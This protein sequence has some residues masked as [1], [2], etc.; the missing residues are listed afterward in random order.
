[1]LHKVRHLIWRAANE[2]L[3]TLHNLL[4]RN[5]VKSTHYPNCKSDGEDTI[6][7]LW[8]CKWLMVVWEADEEMMKFTKQKHILFADFWVVLLLKKDRVDV[9]LLVVIFWL[10]W[11]RRN[12][13]QMGESI[14]NYHQIRARVDLYLLFKSTKVCERR[15]VAEGISTVRWRPPN[16][17]YYKINFD[18]AV[19]SDVEAASLGVV[20]CDSYGR[21]IGSLAECVP[22]LTSVTTV[23]ALAC[24][25]LYCLPRS[26]AFL[27]Q[28]LKGMQ[29][30]SSRRCWAKR[31]II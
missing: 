11:N 21:V 18:G 16:P 25:G 19:F 13:E 23:E 20:I 29:S 31:C 8:S 7:A 5:V 1:M 22:L 14:L 12:A 15:V 4:C 30:S 28:C 10:F 17:N 6:H 26:C 3:P 27:M 2:A 9:D 24:R